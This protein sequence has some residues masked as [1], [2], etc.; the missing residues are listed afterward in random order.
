MFFSGLGIGTTPSALIYHGINTTVVEIDPMIHRLALDHFKLPRNHTA[1][2]EDATTFVK[3][4]VVEMAQEIQSMPAD[5]KGTAKVRPGR[6]DYIVHDVFTG[7][8]EPVELFTEAF[9]RG[10][11]FLLRPDGVIAIVRCSQY[12]YCKA[13]RISLMLCRTMLRISI[14]HLHRTSSRL[15][16][17]CFPIAGSSVK[18]TL[19]R[20][21]HPTRRLISQTWFSFVARRRSR[22]LSASH[23][24]QIALEVR[25]GVCC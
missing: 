9:L 19:Q 7:G 16:S 5:S 1:Y 12:S 4:G 3:N 25:P 2:I 18:P 13:G 11:S 17:V 8:A 22:S 20:L 23:L 24:R 14:Y 10:L 6:Y 21:L 15:S